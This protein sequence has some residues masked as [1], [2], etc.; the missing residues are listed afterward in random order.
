MTVYPDQHN[1]LNENF[2]RPTVFANG[3]SKFLVC[4]KINCTKEF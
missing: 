1:E 2:E 4:T 3:N